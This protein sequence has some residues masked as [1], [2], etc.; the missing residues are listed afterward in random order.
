MTSR[1]LRVETRNATVFE[2]TCVDASYGEADGFLILH[3]ATVS[4]PDRS[5]FNRDR[6]QVANGSI[7]FVEDLTNRDESTRWVRVTLRDGSVF[8]GIF[9]RDYETVI[10][11][12]INGAHLKGKTRRVV[13]I[14]HVRAH[15][16]SLPDTEVYRFH[17]TQ[18]V[19]DNIRSI[20]ALPPPV[21]KRL[22]EDHLDEFIRS[23]FGVKLSEFPLDERIQ[24]ALAS[25]LLLHRY[26]YPQLAGIC[27]DIVASFVPL[28]NVRSVKHSAR[29][30][31]LIPLL[32]ELDPANPDRFAGNEDVEFYEFRERLSHERSG[33]RL[34]R[35]RE[36][37]PHRAPVYSHP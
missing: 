23:E 4:Y 25:Q 15:G 28:A 11:T 8:D 2:G 10:R 12:D 36:K 14:H 27:R 34:H 16:P 17:R 6:I 37:K 24:L 20:D 22:P 21:P 26:E 1:L 7:V 5:H 35:L 33:A 29:L 31:G 19:R 3:N 13:E 30:R 18:L 32:L 9:R